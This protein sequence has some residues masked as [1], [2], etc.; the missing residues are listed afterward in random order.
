MQ[1]RFFIPGDRIKPIANGLGSCIAS[2]RIMVDGARVGYMYREAPDDEIDSGWRFFAG[3]ETQDYA[4]RPENF[5]IYDVNTVANYDPEIVPLLGVPA[6]CAF[7][8]KKGSE[9]FVRT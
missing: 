5:E 1:K 4:N 2:D 7:E 3:D 8:R 6:P 9:G